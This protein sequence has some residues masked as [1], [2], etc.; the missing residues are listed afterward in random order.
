MFSTMSFR[1]PPQ[2][3]NDEMK[4]IFVAMLLAFTLT[5]GMA[6]VTVLAQIGNR[7]SL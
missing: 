7:G 6:I 2:T 1:Y 5:T 3:G 4:K